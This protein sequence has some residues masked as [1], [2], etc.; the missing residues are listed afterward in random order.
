MEVYVLY[1]RVYFSKSVIDTEGNYFGESPVI[2]VF[3]NFD[4]ALKTLKEYAL[5]AYNHLRECW[6]WVVDDS[7]MEN[8]T[9]E[10][11]FTNYNLEE[12]ED[13]IE[14]NV[15]WEYEETED[16]VYWQMMPKYIPRDVQI[17]ILAGLHIR[18]VLVND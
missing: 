14:L 17:P 6:L 13:P 10:D 7:F 5:E 9:E 1:G 3:T 18:K 8:T 4:S 12:E 15:C 16:S 2:K 11:L